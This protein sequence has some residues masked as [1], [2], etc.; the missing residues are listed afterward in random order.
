MEICHHKDLLGRDPAVDLA[1][2]KEK[3]MN[4]IF[5]VAVQP[6]SCFSVPPSALQPWLG[7]GARSWTQHL[8]KV[9]EELGHDGKSPD[10]AKH[11]P[12]SGAKA[13]VPWQDLVLSA[14]Y[15]WP[16]HSTSLWVCI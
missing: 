2:S 16:Q 14:Q 15:L 9:C 5:P 8:Q 4:G 3:K 12:F 13:T 1:T 6:R 11:F 10:D 7:S